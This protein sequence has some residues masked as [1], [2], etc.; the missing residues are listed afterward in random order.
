VINRD[1]LTAAEKAAQAGYDAARLVRDQCP[2]GA[3]LCEYR[4]MIARLSW[5]G[6]VNPAP[7]EEVPEAF[8]PSA[9]RKIRAR[10]R[11][12][13][14]I[15]Q[16]AGA[17]G[18]PKYMVAS[19]CRALALRG[20]IR[21]R[22]RWAG[23]SARHPVTRTD[24]PSAPP[25]MP[26]TEAE[27][28]FLGSYSAQNSLGCTAS[29]LGVS[30]SRCRYVAYALAYAGLI[31]LPPSTEFPREFTPG[32]VRKI[33]GAR[34]RGESLEGIARAL[35]IEE[36]KVGSIARA[37]ELCG[38][39]PVAGRIGA[40]TADQLDRIVIMA[41]A[42]TT[43][44]EIAEALGVG[45]KTVATASRQLRKDGRLVGRAPPRRQDDWGQGRALIGKLL[46]EGLAPMEVARQAGF[47][48]QRVYQVRKELRIPGRKVRRD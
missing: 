19:A 46:R 11:R 15:P 16:T 9:M 7:D 4:A 35:S 13:L 36:R 5:L 42:G 33:R 38:D 44:P 25:H 21:L 40:L 47:T 45:I 41:Q 37:L 27:M 34:K 28:E 12:G 39:L 26:L 43:Q 6:L 24:A 48:S 18:L 22:T 14:T 29:R 8:R 30:T 17:L 31:E 2:A 23:V 10:A 1:L 20:D 32:V 3:K